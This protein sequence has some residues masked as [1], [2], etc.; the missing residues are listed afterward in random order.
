MRKVLSLVLSLVMLLSLVVPVSAEDTTFEGSGTLKD[1]TAVFTIEADKT[2]LYDTGEEQVVKFHIYVES[3]SKGPIRAFQFTLVPSDNLTLADKTMAEDGTFYYT[4]GNA[5][6]MYSQIAYTP[7]SRYFGAAGTDEGKGIT[8]KTEIMTIMGKVNGVGEY[9]LSMMGVVAGNGDAPDTV[10]Q[11]FTSTVAGATVTVKPESKRPQPNLSLTLST[12]KVSVGDT[13]TATLSNKEMSIISLATQIR[14]N[15]N[16]LEVVSI[17]EGAGYT[18][19]VSGAKTAVI[20]TVAD[21]NDRG[22]VGISVAKTVETTYPAK[23]IVTVTFKAK[24]AGDGWIKVDES[25]DGTDGYRGDISGGTVTV[26]EAAQV[27]KGD[28]NGDGSVT[29]NDMLILRQYLA[30]NITMTEGQLLAADLNGDS[31]VTIND[32]LIL[33]QYLA[34]NISSLN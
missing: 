8:T 18:N 31:N 7:S 5:D 27:V 21:A 34:G 6:G 12:D 16:V 2:T 33:R 1:K 22:V 26:E 25:T 20:A 24:A 9:T 17:A 23:D 13:F 15:T 3:E 28:M 14:F 4:N 32:M 19:L 11:K 10:T 29:I 30:G